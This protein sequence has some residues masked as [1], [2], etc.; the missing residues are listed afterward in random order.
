MVP[1]P[2]ITAQKRLPG[3]LKYAAAGPAQTSTARPSEVHTPDLKKYAA[4]ANS[5]RCPN[6]VSTINLDACCF[7]SLWFFI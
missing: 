4:K 1:I 5:G 7:H 2:G 6:R 3:E